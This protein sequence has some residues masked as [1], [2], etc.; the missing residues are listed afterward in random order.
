[1]RSRWDQAANRHKELH[2]EYFFF[3][4]ELTLKTKKTKT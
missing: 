4:G 2:K 3:I 1:M